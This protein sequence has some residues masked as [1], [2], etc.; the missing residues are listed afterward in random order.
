MSERRMKQEVCTARKGDTTADLALVPF[1]GSNLI[2]FR[3]SRI[4]GLSRC[5]HTR[6][7]DKNDSLY[8]RLQVRWLALFTPLPSS[9]NPNYFELPLNTG[10]VKINYALMAKNSSWTSHTALIIC[11]LFQIV[12]KRQDDQLIFQR[13]ALC[14]CFADTGQRLL[15]LDTVIV[16]NRFFEA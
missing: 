8:F 11:A 2:R 1:A 7:S 3:G 13:K 5:F 10:A 6:H 12:I 4:N 16:I 9:C 14:Q 15:E